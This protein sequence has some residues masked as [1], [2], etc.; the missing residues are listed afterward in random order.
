MLFTLSKLLGMRLIF[1]PTALKGLDTMPAKEAKAIVD[2]LEAISSN[3]LAP[4]A[5]VKRLH[6][7]KN[8]FRLRRGDWRATYRIDIAANEMVVDRVAHRRE[9]YR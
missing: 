1:G 9:V 4:H 8:W 6:G 5:N 7:E 3:P 2:G